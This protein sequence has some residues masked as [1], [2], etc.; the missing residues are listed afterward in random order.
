MP[1]RETPAQACTHLH[2]SLLCQLAFTIELAGRSRCLGFQPFQR[3]RHHLAEHR[4]QHRGRD[5]ARIAALAAL[6]AGH[7]ELRHQRLVDP[8]QRIREL[9]EVLL[10]EA[11]FRAAIGV[12]RKLGCLRQGRR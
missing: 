3:I 2:A 5:Q 1:S 11:E 9:G 7:Q 8:G 4:A 12:D 6:P 10:G